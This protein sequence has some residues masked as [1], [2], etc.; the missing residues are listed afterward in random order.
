MLIPPTNALTREALFLYGKLGTGKSSVWS[1]IAYWYRQ[2]GN[3]SKFHVIS[4]EPERAYVMVEQYPD[5]ADNIIV[6]EPERTFESLVAVSKMVNSVATK[7]DWI[8]VDSIGSA[9]DWV[10]NAWF[11]K[12]QGKSWRDFQAAGQS[13]KEVQS[14]QWISMSETYKQWMLDYVLGFP[15]HRIAIAQAD[16][17]NQDGTWD[18]G[19]IRDTYGRIGFKPIG[20]KND[21]FYFH[22]VFYASR[23]RDGKNLTLTTIKDKPARQML[24]NVD[25]M[26]LPGGFV[27]TYLTT[28]AGWTIE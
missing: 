6:Y 20:Y 13:I 26:A 7:D 3:E 17:V 12:N 22:S 1:N 18:A 16:A 27:A 19:H 15:G 28:V 5:W 4:T 11:E 2:Q 8:V 23:S 25:V 24:D 14:H 9:Q 21:D 10:R